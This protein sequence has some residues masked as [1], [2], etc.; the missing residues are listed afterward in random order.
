[1]DT[2]SADEEHAALNRVTAA[3]GQHDVAAITAELTAHLSSANITS[4]C[5]DAMLGDTLA[6][7]AA[8]TADVLLLALEAVRR[9][10][11]CVK[12]ISTAWLLSSK[13]VHVNNALG[14]T[15]VEGGALEL[16][17]SIVNDTMSVPD[18]VLA[19]FVLV[20]ALLDVGYA[21]RAVQMG[22]VEVR[23]HAHNVSR[24]FYALTTFF[25][26][27]YSASGATLSRRCAHTPRGVLHSPSRALHP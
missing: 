27:G 18:A 3:R 7:A 6:P 10:P 15:A 25:P 19:S 14:R 23:C 13:L 8:A 21:A 16:A 22:I 12:V 2:L 24:Y 20:S 11:G 1:M 17:L 5:C 9:H 26:S 4:V